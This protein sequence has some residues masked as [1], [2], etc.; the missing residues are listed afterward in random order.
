[1]G[2]SEQDTAQIRSICWDRLRLFPGR[3]GLR[4]NLVG[5]AYRGLSRERTTL[6]A[7]I[8]YVT[9]STNLPPSRI[10]SRLYLLPAS[11]LRA[12]HLRSTTLAPSET[13]SCQAG[14]S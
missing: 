4:Q 8:L 1:M 5:N 11:D 2:A 13:S 9:G 14:V 6:R 12:R 10:R 7:L 3:S